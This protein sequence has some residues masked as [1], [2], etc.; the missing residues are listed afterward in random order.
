[1]VNVNMISNETKLSFYLIS[2]VLLLSN[3]VL[4]ED[5]DFTGHYRMYSSSNF[6]EFLKVL[7]IGY[8]QR[9]AASKTTPDYLITKKGDTYTL[10]TKTALSDN[11]IT[12]QDGVEFNEDRLDGA[13]LRT[14][15]NIE[16]QKW[17]QKQFGQKPEV[18]IVRE[19]KDNDIITTSVAGG[20]TS[21]RKYKKVK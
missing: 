6:D 16:G 5:F 15:I 10:R 14:V 12:F 3:L 1:M 7:G 21:V 13:K 11:S 8:F 19:W 2:L 20:V 17:T 9:L 18:T 4:A